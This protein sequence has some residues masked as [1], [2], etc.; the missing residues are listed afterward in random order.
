[1]SVASLDCSMNDASGSSASDE[2]MMSAGGRRTS[3]MC[4]Q[5]DTAF[6]H[7]RV[8][9]PPSPRTLLRAKR[10]AGIL[11]FGLVTAD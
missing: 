8:E 3:M 10:D 1:M 5:D 11:V 2:F 4:E 6:I 7:G 9:Q